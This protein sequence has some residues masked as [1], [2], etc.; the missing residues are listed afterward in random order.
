MW[1]VLW[2]T[3]FIHNPSQNTWAVTMLA[4]TKAVT[5]HMGRAQITM[6]PMNPMKARTKAR[7]CRLIVLPRKS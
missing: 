6:V 3:Q 4:P 2:I 7:I 5:F 1:P